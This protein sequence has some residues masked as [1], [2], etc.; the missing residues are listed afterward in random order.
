MKKALVVSAL[1]TVMALALTAGAAQAD[2]RVSVFPP[3]VQF[4]AS[5]PVVYS[6]PGYYYSYPY[7]Y[8][9]PSYGYT[10]YGYPYT[11]SYPSDYYPYYSPSRVIIQP[12]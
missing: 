11:Y 5:P 3:F 6:A 7:T 10:Y 12:Q 2:V 4:Y 9:Y 8:S 1:L